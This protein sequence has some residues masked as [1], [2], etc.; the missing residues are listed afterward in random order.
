MPACAAQRRE[1]RLLF[2]S[3]RDG[4]SFNTFFGRVSAT[5]GPTLLLIREKAAGSNGI[6]ADGAWAGSAGGGNDGGNNGGS[7]GGRLFGGYAPQPWA[8]SGTFYGDVSSFIF[9]LEPTVEVGSCGRAQ[10]TGASPTQRAKGTQCDLSSQV[11]NSQVER[12]LSVMM[13]RVGLTQ[14]VAGPCRLV[15]AP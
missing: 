3:H 5:P 2:S 6:G 12:G 1:W 11:S 7:G 10:R 4:K 14:G 15:L 13:K 9:R 8:K